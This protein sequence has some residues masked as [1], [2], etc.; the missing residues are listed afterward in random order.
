MNVFNIL[1]AD[2]DLHNILDDFNIEEALKKNGIQVIGKAYNADELSVLLADKYNQVNAVIVDANMDESHYKVN[3]E[4]NT[5]GLTAV[6]G[7][8]KLYWNKYNIPFYLYTGRSRTD[9][10]NKY[11]DDELRYFKQPGHWFEKYGEEYK[12][13]FE[14]ITKDVES[15]NSPSFQLHN[16]YKSEFEAASLIDDASRLLEQGLMY[17]YNPGWKDT[18]DFFNPARKIIERI[19]NKLQEQKLLPPISSLNSMSKLLLQGKYE[20]QD[21]SFELKTELMHP[22]LAHSLKYFLEI[23]QDGSHDSGDLKLGVDSYIRKSQNSNLYSSILYI[24]MDLLLWY[25]EVLRNP[26]PSEDI[27]IGSMKYEYT[28]KLCLSPDGRYWYSGEYEI[29]SDPSFTDG[30]IVAIKKS[31][32][33]KKPKPGITKFVP[34]GC[35]VIIED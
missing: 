4:R 2:D 16:K 26:V 6:L 32:I 30:A 33:N 9:L 3:D 1:W 27:W 19:F 15:I 29:L 18:Q 8:V 23:T 24:A 17:D 7:L 5:S 12:R 14:Q 25:K 28:G 20:D 10:L 13:L 31:I 34:K 21:C 11:P 35:C 22:A